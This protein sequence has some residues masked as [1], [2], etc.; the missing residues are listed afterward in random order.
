MRVG[1]AAASTR[2][3]TSLT[4]P[5]LAGWRQIHSSA[6]ELKRQ[7]YGPAAPREDAELPRVRTPR[8]HEAIELPRAGPHL[9]VVTGLWPTPDMPSAG[10]FVRR[11]LRGIKATVIGPT[12]FQQAMP[13][14]YLRLA[15]RAMT[16]RGQ[17]DGVEAHVLFPT[18]LIGL[19]AGRLRGLPVVVYSHGA[20]VRVTA[21]ENVVYRWLARLVARSADAVVTNSEATA[22]QIRKLGREAEVIPPGVDLSSFKPS[23]RP[24][25]K[26]V[27]YIGGK[28][29][30][31]GYD[32]AVRV[33]NTLVG[34]GLDEIRPDEVPQLIAEHDVVLVPSREEPFGLAAAEAIACGRWVVAANVGGLR[35]VIMDGVN[36]TLVNGEDF[37]GAVRAVPDFNPE[38]VA[39]TAQRFSLAQ[40]QRRMAELWRAV[41]QRA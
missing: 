7:L 20:D 14:R 18:G 34:P 36:G 13:L 39:A 22:E 4:S 10:I 21:Q 35:E 9:L 1:Q 23:P 33:A 27:L 12:T 6:A 15:F 17:F 28:R 3:P 40:H 25:E 16:Q 29:L 26:R 24:T 19:V 2:S 38:V 5:F 37:E 41:L 32:R 11:R 31:K 8:P 30:H